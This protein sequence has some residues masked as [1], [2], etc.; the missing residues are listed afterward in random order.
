MPIA[1]DPSRGQETPELVSG[2]AGKPLPESPN[3]GCSSSDQSE[4]SSSSSNQPERDWSSSVR[5]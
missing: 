3:D 5:T 4:L 2:W 1:G